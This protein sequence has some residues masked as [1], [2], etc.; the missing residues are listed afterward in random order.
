MT[1]E[2]STIYTMHLSAKHFTSPIVIIQWIKFYYP[3]FIEGEN[4]DREKLYDD[5]ASKGDS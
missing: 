5:K 2:A 1:P 3:Y 4:E